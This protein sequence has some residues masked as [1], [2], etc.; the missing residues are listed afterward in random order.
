MAAKR[1]RGELLKNMPRLLLF[2]LISVFGSGA[3]L[4]PLDIRPGQFTRSRSMAT[5][6][7][8]LA[9]GLF[10][11]YGVCGSAACRSFLRSL[12]RNASTSSAM[13]YFSVSIP[14]PLTAEIS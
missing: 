5:T 9:V 12:S 14:L 2:I 10:A 4:A 8:D 11:I 6:P 1:T 3:F 13:A 7:C